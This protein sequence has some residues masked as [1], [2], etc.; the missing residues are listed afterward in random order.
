M[1]T[2][3]LISAAFAAS[4]L[5]SVAIPAAAFTVYPDVDF[6]WYANVGKPLASPPVEVIL[7]APREGYM[8]SPGHWETRGTHQVWVPAQYVK[9]DYQQQLIV[10]N[11]GAATYAT[12]PFMI[13]DSQGNVIPTNPEAYP[14]GS[15]RK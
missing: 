5:A 8:V 9:D 12:G 13:R 4:A 2:H 3:K 15:A 6:E 1:R 11:S 10:Y 14:V 7:L